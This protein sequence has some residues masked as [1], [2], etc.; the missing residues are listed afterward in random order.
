MIHGRPHRGGELSN[1]AANYETILK[2]VVA[3]PP[4]TRLTLVQDVLKSLV[5]VLDAGR[6]RRNTLHEALGLL[7]TGQP[8]PSD[9]EIQRLLDERRTE[10]FG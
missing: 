8:A 9:A 2:T 10:K 1:E 5:P 3:W 4:A 7:A 6:P